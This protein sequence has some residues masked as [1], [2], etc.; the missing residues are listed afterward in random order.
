MTLHDELYT[1]LGGVEVLTDGHGESVQFKGRA[2]SEPRTITTL[3]CRLD[4]EF[5]QNGFVESE[6]ETLYVGV[7]RNDTTGIGD[8]E[9]T[10]KSILIYDDENRP[11]RFSGRRQ[12]VRDDR[13]TLIFERERPIRH[14][15]QR[16]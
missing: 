8:I 12:N 2:D 9:L 3:Q 5:A 10:D 7:L 16:Q 14:G 4:G 6:M 13:W 1:D 15:G 11:F